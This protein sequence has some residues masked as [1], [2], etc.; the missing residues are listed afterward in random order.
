MNKKNDMGALIDKI[1]DKV[2]NKDCFEFSHNID[3]C[4]IKVI[5]YK[6]KVKFDGCADAYFGI[7]G[8]CDCIFI[9]P[10]KV[11]I[12]ECTTG[13]FG[14]R[15]AK[16]KPKQIK[17]CYTIVRDLGYRGLIEA[18]IYYEK[19]DSTSKKRVE[20]ELKDIKKKDSGFIVKFLRCGA[21]VLC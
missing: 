8:G 3:G 17:K 15:D 11:C 19:I 7:E 5:S 18:V 13:K 1:T 6:F 14:S 2:K 20:I 12:V 16:R 10:H 4:K 9:F 21:D